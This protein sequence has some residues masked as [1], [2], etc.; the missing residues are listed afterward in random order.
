MF[1]LIVLT[2]LLRFLG[3][4]LGRGSSLPGL[5]ALRLC[6]DVLGRLKLPDTVVAV[7]GSN[8]KTS[9]TELVRKAA[10][11]T[12]KRVVCNSEGSNQTEGVATA[13]LSAASLTGR[14]RADIVILESD[15]RFCQYTFRHI[16]PSHIAVLNLYRDQLTRNG[17]SEF[18]KGELKKGLPEGSTLI[19]NAD[20]PMSASLA[21]GRTAPVLWFG[22]S[23]DAMREQGIPH[24]YDDG[25]YCPVC[26]G[27]MVYDYRVFA[28]LG[29][30]RCTRCEFARPTPHHAV[31]GSEDG[32]YTM[33][34]R[35]RIVPQLDNPTPSRWR[36]LG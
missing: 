27:E 8:G 15:E 29:G 25:A 20:E 16:T 7:T 18:V 22:V 5:V 28:H 32:V 33:D 13:L 3:G 19:L 1:F 14:V 17:S 30:Y 12:G 26:T 10:L 34:G 35:H 9:T 2:K 6:P 23:P 24:A 21:E 36:Y 31:T 4:L 11:A